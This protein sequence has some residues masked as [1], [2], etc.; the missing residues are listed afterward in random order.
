MSP[1]PEPG[2]AA[3]NR[4]MDMTLPAAGQNANDKGSR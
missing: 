3:L 1:V 2:A 4:G